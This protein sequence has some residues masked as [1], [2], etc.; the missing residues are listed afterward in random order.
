MTRMLYQTVSACALWVLSGALLCG[1]VPAHAQ[2]A[3]HDSVVVTT[4]TEE[5][6][7]PDALA[8][9]SRATDFLMTMQRLHIEAHVV[10]DVIQEDGRR[11]QFEKQGE[12]YLQRPDQ[13][14]A[15][16]FLDDERH[17][18]F[19]YDGKTLSLAERSRNQHTQTKAPPTIDAM[20]DMLEELIKDPM[21][22]ADILYSDL[23]PLEQ[24]AIE[25]DVVG[26]SL[27]AGKMCT[28]LAFRGKTVDWQLWVD[29]GKQPF[30]HK[31]SISYREEPGVPQYTAW[32]DVWGTPNQF[33]EDLFNFTVPPGSEFIKILV[34]MPLPADEGGQP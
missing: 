26:D 25:A 7:D 20:L 12:I 19:W 2:T 5:L 15:E 13:L 27:V 1:G 17:R 11:L 10:Y 32:I 22:L 29:Q 3:T 18:Q 21:P 9:L 28:Q 23:A 4:T 14:F 24:Q 30:I 6:R 8:E 33:K 31:L 34:P 16:V